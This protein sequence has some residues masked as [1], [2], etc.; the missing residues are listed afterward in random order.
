V[1]LPGLHSP[2]WAPQREPTL[3]AAM[4]AESAI[5]LDRLQAG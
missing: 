2:Q 5:L 3:K 4:A 1:A